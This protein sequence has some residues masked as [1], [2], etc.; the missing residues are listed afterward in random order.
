VN[1]EDTNL[2]RLPSFDEIAATC[3]PLFAQYR[4]A[5]ITDPPPGQFG[6]WLA[7]PALGRLLAG[8]FL[9]R[10]LTA[11]LDALIGA[12][13]ASDVVTCGQDARLSRLVGSL[14]DWIDWIKQPWPYWKTILGFAPSISI[15]IWA[16]GVLKWK[17]TEMIFAPFIAMLLLLNII[18]LLFPIY[19]GWT[20]SRKL[21]CTSGSNFFRE[22][23]AAFERLNLRPLIEPPFCLYAL[24]SAVFAIEI[25]GSISTSG[26][27]LRIQ[28]S[29]ISAT[30]H[31][32]PPHP[33]HGGLS[34][35]TFCIFQL[36]TI[37]SGLT[38]HRWMRANASDDAL[39]GSS[40]P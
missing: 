31:K 33:P 22:E 27:L 14:K 13:T 39:C 19:N 1:R 7:L 16:H 26:L 32:P 37:V 29:G 10:S 30:Y 6:G 40:A 17:A 12:L 8:Y 23:A 15:F 38:V 25:I 11:R 36:I 34:W 3:Q 28:T 5:L 21:L 35:F 2:H 18:Q 9:K 4:Q 24:W 20:A